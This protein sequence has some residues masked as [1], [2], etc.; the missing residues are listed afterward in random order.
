MAK[1]ASDYHPFMVV[2]KVEPPASGWFSRAEGTV[3]SLRFKDLVV[4]VSVSFQELFVLPGHG[5]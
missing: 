2:V 3:A 5:H 1:D 4:E